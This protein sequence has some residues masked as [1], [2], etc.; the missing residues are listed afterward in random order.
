MITSIQNNG[1][2]ILLFPKAFDLRPGINLLGGGNGVGKTT[3]LKELRLWSRS[4]GFLLGKDNKNYDIFRSEEEIR[5][6]AAKAMKVKVEDDGNPARCFFWQ[7]AK[8][9]LR[10]VRPNE[11]LSSFLA[12]SVDLFE[13][14]ERSEGENVTESLLR[15]FASLNLQK[16]DILFLDEVDSGL[17]VDACNGIIGYLLEN[18]NKIGFQ[19]I[20]TC[21]SFHFPYVCGHLI[22]LL[23]GKRYDFHKSYEEFCEFSYRNARK[24]MPVREKAREKE[25]KIRERACKEREKEKRMW[26][27]RRNRRGHRI[28]MSTRK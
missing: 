14:Q 27:E 15:W 19:A 8:D 10:Y 16:G 7:N 12:D 17:S 24:L 18:S 11:F 9:N 25:K 6:Q 22:N 28:P 4:K 26:D 13:S 5:E 2:P 21:N 3:L 1:N 20:V 23:D